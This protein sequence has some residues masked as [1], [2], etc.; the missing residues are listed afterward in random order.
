MSRTANPP[1]WSQLTSVQ[2]PGHQV[3]IL[4]RGLLGGE[5]PRSFTALRWRALRL[6]LERL[7]RDVRRR[8]D[9]VGLSPTGRASSGSSAPRKSPDPARPPRLVPKASRQLGGLEAFVRQD[10]RCAGSHL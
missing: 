4:H 3:K 9:V 2:R 7:D 10:G 8:T 5:V 1:A 6:S